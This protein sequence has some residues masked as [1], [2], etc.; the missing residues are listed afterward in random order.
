M[1]KQLV[2]SN[3]MEKN[4]TLCVWVP[5]GCCNK[6]PLTGW[7]NTTQMYSPIVLGATSPKSRCG[8]GHAPSKSSRGESFLASHLLVAP[9]AHWCVAASFQSPPPS[10]CGHLLF[11]PR[12][13]FLCISCLQILQLIYLFSPSIQCLGKF[14]YDFKLG[15]KLFWVFKCPRSLLWFLICVS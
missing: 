10:P 14:G 1:W 9:R 2:V 3:M 6:V 13:S 12:V 11:S 4:R 15:W 5:C 7:L 8:Q